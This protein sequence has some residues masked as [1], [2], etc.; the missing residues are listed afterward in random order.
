MM[1]VYLAYCVAGIGDAVAQ[2]QPSTPPTR[3][4]VYSLSTWNQTGKA[5]QRRLLVWQLQLLEKL[6]HC[7]RVY[8]PRLTTVVMPDTW[9]S[10]EL[11]YSPLPLWYPAAAQYAKMIVVHLPTQVFGG[12][13]HG[14]LVQWGPVSTGRKSTPTPSGLFHLNWKSTGRHST[15]NPDWF[16]PWYFNF[17]NQRGLSFHEYR[18][19]GYPASHACIRLLSRD[20]QWLYTWGEEW[21]LDATGRKVLQHGTPVIIL[22]AYDHEA[23][24]PWRSLAWL[25]TGIALPPA[26]PSEAAEFAP[27]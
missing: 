13:E 26:I 11:R 25:A 21:R 15:I 27:D 19:P 7:D 22:G 6:N 1:V 20:A 18:L 12:Y 2:W 3:E 4:M 10:D 24:P 8:L 9:T 17:D 16:M 5:M 23:P 14:H